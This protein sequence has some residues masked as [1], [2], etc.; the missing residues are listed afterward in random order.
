M[1][2]G[3]TGPEPSDLAELAAR[4]AREAGHLLIEAGRHSHDRAA[5]ADSA[6]RKSSA[7]DLATEADR[8]SERLIV[9]G[10]SRARPDDA[11]LG[12]EGGEHAG[13]SGLTWIIDP[14]DGTTNFVYGF[15]SWAVSIGVADEA[16]PLAGAVYDPLRDEMFTAARGCAA[17]LGDRVLGPLAAP[18]LAESLVGTGFSYAEENRRGQARLLPV[19]LPRVRDIRRAGAASLDLCYVAAGRLNAFYEAGLHPWDRAAG[20]LVATEAGADY[21]DVDGLDPGRSTLVVAPPGLLDELLALL[22]EAAA[23]P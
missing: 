12:E 1:T 7:T 5:L 15:G 9:G 8:A 16:G 6:S 22:V 18:P 23:R 20:L 19:V 13:S 11:V 14:I 10:I 4:L 17:R 3:T 21:R 2:G